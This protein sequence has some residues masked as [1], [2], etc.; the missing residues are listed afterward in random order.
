MSLLPST[1]LAITYHQTRM[2]SILFLLWP[3]LFGHAIVQTSWAMSPGSRIVSVA[4]S[5]HVAMPGPKPGQAVAGLEPHWLG[6]LVPGRFCPYPNSTWWMRWPSLP[7]RPTRSPLSRAVGHR[8]LESSA[9]KCL[10]RWGVRPRSPLH[11][12][13]IAADHLQLVFV[14]GPFC[15]LL[16]LS[17][18]NLLLTLKHS[19]P[20]SHCGGSL[21]NR[22]RLG[23]PHTKSAAWRKQRCDCTRTS[24]CRCVHDRLALPFLSAAPTVRQQSPAHAEAFITNPAASSCTAF[25]VG[26]WTVESANATTFRW[27]IQVARRCTQQGAMILRHQ[28]G[29]ASFMECSSVMRTGVIC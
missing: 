9:F 28:A 11:H 19:P 7:S 20:L 13:R 10:V 4:T 17:G 18:S 21:V 1:A 2:W 22:G 15:L 6:Q 16:L 24:R 26:G 25:Y 5:A 29:S 23:H 14:P 27:H 8:P 12:C 3:C